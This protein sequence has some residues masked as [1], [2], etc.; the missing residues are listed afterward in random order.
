MSNQQIKGAGIYF[1][2]SA[3]EYFALPYFSRSLAQKVRF[4]GK[5]A[6]YYINNPSA[7][8]PAMEFGTALHSLLL[9]P[10]KFNQTYVKAPALTDEKFFGKKIIQTIDDLKPY[11]EQFGLKKSG[12]KEDLIESVRAY[13]NPAEVVIW[14]DVKA[15][16]DREVVALNQK[17]LKDEDFANLENICDLITQSKFDNL[18]ENG[19][20]EVVII[21][22]DKQSGIMCKCRIDFMQADS[23]IDVKSFSVKDFNTPLIDQLRKKTI[24]SFYNFQFAI[25]AEAIETIIEAIKSGQAE[26]F[27]EVDKNFVESFLKNPIKKFIIFYIRTQAPYQMQALQLQSSEVSGGGDNAYYSVACEMWHSSLKKFAYF[28]KN[29]KWF[30]E[31]EIQ[32][33]QDQHVP[34]VMWQQSAED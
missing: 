8:T 11:L 17:I 34:N 25:Y 26:I 10:K 27:G 13:L 7:E 22:K 30:G 20:P 19:Y 15:N 32:I 2:M 1:N 23:I 9:E 3:E 14:D 21:W 28:L 6:E 5:E 33:L 18:L 16:F 29:G 12:K 31:D 4:S 24:F